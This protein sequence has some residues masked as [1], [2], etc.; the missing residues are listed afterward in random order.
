VD[1]SADEEYDSDDETTDEDVSMPIARKCARR[2]DI[3]ESDIT[4]SEAI[5]VRKGQPRVSRVSFDRA[6]ERPI[7]LF[8]P[9]TRKLVCIT[10]Q[11]VQKM[12]SMPDSMS[13]PFFE[14][15]ANMDFLSSPPTTGGNP[16]G[17]TSPSANIDATLAGISLFNS[18]WPISSTFGGLLEND[19]SSDDFLEDVDEAEKDL[20]IEDFVAIDEDSDEED[21]ENN[22]WNDSDALLSTPAGASGD[23]HSLF[24]HFDNNPDVVGAFRLNQ[25]NA[26]L[27]ASDKAT[28]EG[29]AFANSNSFYQGPIRGIKT[30][31]IDG[32]SVLISP[33]RR[34]RARSDVQ[35][36][37]LANATLKRKAP[38][39]PESLHKKQ[40]SISEVKKLQL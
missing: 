13:F 18:D 23:T 29:L 38:S 34:K 17:W 9:K 26:Q 40:R 3:S 33:E 12:D 37:P 19:L 6:G 15:P 21:G 31:R 25:I 27:I 8:D 36:S 28:A 20:N 16:F 1:P 11:T 10:P 24:N 7:A 35:S 14:M 32:A 22:I 4:D 30:G 39:E 5:V 2:V